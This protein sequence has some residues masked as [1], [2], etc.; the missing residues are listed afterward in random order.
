MGF[1]EK[2][3]LK[4]FSFDSLE[5]KNL[6]QAI[7]CRQGGVSPQPWA[8]LN[9]GGT[10]GDSRENVVENRRRIFEVVGRPVPSLFDVWQIHG[11]NVVCTDMPRALDTPH[12]KADAI[13]TDR[14]EITLLM[15]FADCVP[16]FLYDPVRKV[17]GIVHAGWQGTVQKIGQEAVEIMQNKYKSSPNDIH[18]G[19]GPSIGPDHYEI[20]EDVVE[21][22]QTSFGIDTNQIV[23]ESDRKI[24]MDLWKANQLVLKQAGVK[25]IE[26]S[27]VCTACHPQDWYSHRQELGKTGRFGAVLA[28]KPV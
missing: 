5:L 14:L 8:S 4:Y 7:F 23:L 9:L 25:N 13:L 27:H 1:F 28:L 2:E 22:V 24:F 11:K 19:I 17:I 18:A 26:V 20:G 21:K 6:T 12:Q 15:R 16:I 3:G 10:L